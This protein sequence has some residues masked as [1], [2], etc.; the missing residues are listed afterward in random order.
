MVLVGQGD[1]DYNALQDYNNKDCVKWGKEKKD[2]LLLQC[3]MY[4]SWDDA[5]CSEWDVVKSLNKQSRWDFCFK[6]FNL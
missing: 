4:K 3:F 5:K 1:K 6:T 2:E